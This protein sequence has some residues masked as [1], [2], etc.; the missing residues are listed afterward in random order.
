MEIPSLCTAQRKNKSSCTTGAL[1]ASPNMS[2]LR[3]LHLKKDGMF[4]ESLFSANKHGSMAQVCNIASKQTAWPLER[5]PLDRLD[6]SSNVWLKCTVPC[7]FKTKYSRNISR[8]NSNCQ[9][10]WWNIWAC[11]HSTCSQSVDYEP[12]I[13]IPTNLSLAQSKSRSEWTIRELCIIEG[14]QISRM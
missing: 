11:C 7:L 14:W 12:F 3:T 6:Q 5:C 8:N 2:K 10:R 13:N 1:Q 4:G 9:T